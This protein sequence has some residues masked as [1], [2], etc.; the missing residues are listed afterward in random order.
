MLAFR[1]HNF[2][3]NASGNLMIYEY[4]RLKCMY[5]QLEVT[6]LS[7]VE[8]FCLQKCH[9]LR[10]IIN[11]RSFSHPWMNDHIS[12]KVM[13]EITYQYRNPMLR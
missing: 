3:S 7:W 6:A 8:D 11:L 5:L 12:Y 2:D 10:N 9:I 13:G 1:M 4:L